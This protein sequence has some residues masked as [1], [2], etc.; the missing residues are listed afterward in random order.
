MADTVFPF[1]AA[2]SVA[3]APIALARALDLARPIR[4]EALGYEEAARHR[5]AWLILIRNALEANA[6]L[7]PSFLL[8]AAQHLA[9][10]RRPVF[11]FVWDDRAAHRPALIGLCPVLIDPHARTVTA[12][13]HDYAA[14]GAPLLDFAR[15]PLAVRALLDWVARHTGAC[16]LMLPMLAEFGPTAE[17]LRDC[18]EEE[19]RELRFF[20]G[21][22]RAILPRGAHGWSGL[23]AKGL[24]EL[25]RQRRRLAERGALTFTSA[26]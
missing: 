22:R 26:R 1:W 14:A 4:V 9:Q 12:W 23:R 19:S 5:E 3:P 11:L 20:D 6:F 25:R 10:G 18:A 16:G 21:C 17:I 2:P 13:R 15:A 8:P 24:K 7:E